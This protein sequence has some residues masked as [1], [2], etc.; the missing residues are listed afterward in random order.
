MVKKTKYTRA[1]IKSIRQAYKEK[2]P[3]KRI[4]QDHN[5]K[6]GQVTYIVYRVDPKPTEKKS[7]A[8]PK[9]PWTWAL[10]KRSLDTLGFK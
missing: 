8:Q 9:E 6:Y 2:T 1:Q 5:L 10:I 7:S 3:L 4:A